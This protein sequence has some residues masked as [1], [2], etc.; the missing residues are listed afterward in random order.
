MRTI[1][2]ILASI[3]FAAPL[4]LS[5]SAYAAPNTLVVSGPST[6]SSDAAA[7]VISID[8]DLG[9]TP[10]PVLD[11]YVT[12]D[13]A[14][15]EFVGIN[16]A[17]SPFTA[18]TIDAASGTNFY[19]ISRYSTASP[20]PS[21]AAVIAKLSFRPK[22]SSGTTVVSIDKPQSGLYTEAGADAL[23]G[24]VSH[25][26][27][28]TAPPVNPATPPPATT[29]PTAAPTTASQPKPAATPTAANPNASTT[30]NT[31]TT[32]APSATTPN[33]SA[34][35]AQPQGSVTYKQTAY[36]GGASSAVSFFAKTPVRIGLITAVSGSLLV[37]AYFATT[38]L[39]QRRYVQ[40]AASQTAVL[41]PNPVAGGITLG[42]DPT[43]IQ[44]QGPK[45][46]T[47]GEGP[48]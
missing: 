19:K 29:A 27:T 45:Q 33:E 22:V 15:L 13:P 44:P 39:R 41:P 26:I 25:T 37:T 3:V 30:S 42:Y 2:R 7:I 48:M 43:V 47:N 9:S 1:R 12:F 35:A 40:M 38:G 23:V 32:T 4:L 28:F 31:Q 14:K 8:A 16:Y 34:P 5:A 17:G 20:Y 36:S 6:V 10:I 18:D 46:P 24:T 21:G 11:A